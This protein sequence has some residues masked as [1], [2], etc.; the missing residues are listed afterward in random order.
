MAL[1]S[2]AEAHPAIRSVEIAWRSPVEE[3]VLVA[4]AAVFIVLLSSVAIG[5]ERKILGRPA[6]T[7]SASLE[8]FGGTPP[9]QIAFADLPG[10]AQRV[11]RAVEEGLVEAE[12]RRSATGSWPSIEDLG[13]GGIPPFADD[14]ID[15]AGYVWQMLHDKNVANYLGVPSKVKTEPAFLIVVRE[16]EPGMLI[17]PGAQADEV[18]HKLADGTLVHVGGFVGAAGEAPKELMPWAPGNWKQVFLNGLEPAPQ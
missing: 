12:A 7:A 4:K 15:R 6:F 8:A 5:V 13:R 9:P 14:P 17:V 2:A 1:P 10:P 16:P 11:F 18:H 3:T